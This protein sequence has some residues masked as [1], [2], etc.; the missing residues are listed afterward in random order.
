MISPDCNSLLAV[1]Q[2]SLSAGV[3]QY[4]QKRANLRV[5][6]GIYP[7]RVVLWLMILQRL[8]AEGTLAIAVQL[9]LQG[10]AAPLLPNCRRVRRRRISAHTGG[11]CRARQKLPTLLCRQVMREMLLQLKRILGRNDPEQ[12]PVF[13]LDG[14]SLE[15]EH[16]RELVRTYPPAE[17]QNG[18]AHWPVL[19]IV[20]MHDVYSGLAEEP[21][22]GPMYGQH[23][24]SEQELAEKA[25]DALP[26][27]AVVVGDRNFGILWT[28]Y[29]AHRMS[30]AVVLRLSKPRAHKLLG[31]IAQEG[32]YPV[33]WKPSRW[34]GGKGRRVPAEA[35][36]TGRLLAVRIGR[37]KSKQWLYL[38]TTLD[39][40]V[41]KIVELYGLRWNIETDLRSLKQTVRLNHIAAKSADMMEKEFIMAVA[42]YNLVRAVICMAA[43]RHQLDPRQLSFSGVL[44]AVNAA[45]PKLLAAKTSKQKQREFRRVLDIAAQCTLPRRRKRR[46]YPRAVW[47]HRAGFPFRHERKSK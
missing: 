13:V 38:F 37:G 26:P 1:Y 39:W 25:I 34:D 10:A 7:A 30:R 5:R 22:W 47:R 44:N 21:H 18:R 4:F 40:S 45:W 3:L 11:Y 36:V 35:E 14:S 17:N 41:E 2:R 19:R 15:L 31:P 23:A 20:V 8:S 32:D 16:C 33:T 29:A 28:A 9:L 46:S 24:V 42:A 27:E 12:R 43:Q 6:R